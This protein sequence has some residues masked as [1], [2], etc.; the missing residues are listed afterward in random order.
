MP[1]AEQ[2]DP[3]ALSLMNAPVDDEP[4]TAEDL[5]AIEATRIERRSGKALMSLD[6]FESLVDAR[7]AAGE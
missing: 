6:E 4:L 2:L 5:A 1:L 7:I 3:V